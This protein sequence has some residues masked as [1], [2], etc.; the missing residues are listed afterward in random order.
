LSFLERLENP[1]YMMGRSSPEFN[2]NNQNH[3][4][5]AEPKQAPD[6][7]ERGRQ[8]PAAALRALAEANARR[9]AEDDAALKRP[10]EIGG[11]GGKDPVR[12]GDWEVKG[13]AVDF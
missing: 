3:H 12:Y 7:S 8:L 1:A 2:V 6:G 4:T 9:A 13:R 10:A 5:D 11:R